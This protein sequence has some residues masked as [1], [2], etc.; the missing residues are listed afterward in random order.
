M[1]AAADAEAAARTPISTLRRRNSIETPSSLTLH[2]KHQHPSSSS[3]SS[4]SSYTTAT[5]SSST[6]SSSSSADYEL[7]SL[8]PASYTSLRDILPS[9]VTFV[10]S[11]KPPSFTVNS[12]YEISIRNRLVKQAAWAYLQPMSTSPGAGGSTVFHR[13]W[14]RLSDAVL[15]LMTHICDCLLRSTQVAATSPKL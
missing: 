15:R 10:Q 7:V 14:N 6:T 2:T 3:S 9:T 13:L 4:S 5:T 8:K 12:G 11:P 1:D